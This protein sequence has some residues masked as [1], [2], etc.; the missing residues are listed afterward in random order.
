[1]T[2]I[3]LITSRKKHDNPKIGIGLGRD[4]KQNSLI[5]KAVSQFLAHEKATIFLFSEGKVI[6]TLSSDDNVPPDAGVC[7]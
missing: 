5:V 7:L 2:L 6:D 4:S 3:D 1:M